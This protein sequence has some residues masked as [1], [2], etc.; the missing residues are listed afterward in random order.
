[1]TPR[2]ARVG[3]LD[4]P[5][6][7]IDLEILDRNLERVAAYTR[8]HGLRLRPHTK[9][10]K[11]PALARKQLDLGAF[12]LTVAKVGEAEVMLQA[13]PA[14]LLVAFPIVGPRK[15][16]RLVEVGRNTSVTVSLD[17]LTVAGHLSD[18]ARR[19]EIKLVLPTRLNLLKLGRSGTVAEALDAARRSEIVPVQPEIVETAGGPA[20][21]IPAAA[22]YGV[23][24]V[25]VSSYRRA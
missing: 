14:D 10:H 19:G 7:L 16:E 18:A 20:F 3:E 4:T 11:I 1:M 5:A 8:Q 2:P 12:G 21:R 6:I 24:E 25:L 17:S 13:Q 15:L 9:T 22:D 23:T